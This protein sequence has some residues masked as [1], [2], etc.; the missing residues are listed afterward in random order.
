MITG[1]ES[2]VLSRNVTLCHK[3]IYLVA[4]ITGFESVVSWIYFFFPGRS[5]MDAWSREYKT[6]ILIINS[7]NH[8]YWYSD[9]DNFSLRNARNLRLRTS[10]LPERRC[11]V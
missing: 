7:G 3:N 4:C 9:G 6:C 10:F 5:K 8:L 2:N 1:L 11:C